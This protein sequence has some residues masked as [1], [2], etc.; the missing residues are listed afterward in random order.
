ML[1]ICALAAGSCTVFSPDDE[2]TVRIEGH[3]YARCTGGGSGPCTNVEPVSGAVVST[4]LDSTTAAT[5][6]SGAFDL[7]TNAPGSK[8]GCNVYTLTVT[9]SGHR[10]YSTAASWGT[11]PT[12]QNIVLAD[13]SPNVFQPC[14]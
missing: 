6:A 11:H 10:T 13:G 5:D 1:S 2:E 9:A 14:S 3:V 7:K 8:G 4:S 12:G